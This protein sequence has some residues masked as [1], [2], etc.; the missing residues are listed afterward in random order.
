MDLLMG[1]WKFWNRLKWINLNIDTLRKKMGG[2]SKARNQGLAIAEGEFIYFMDSDDE[3]DPHLI[4]DNVELIKKYDA[5]VVLFGHQT[6]PDGANIANQYTNVKQINCVDKNYFIK[7]YQN[8]FEELVISFFVWN[9]L[10]RKSVIIKNNI[11]FKEN[12]IFGEDALFNLEFFSH[13]K[14][15]VFNPEIYYSYCRRSESISGSSKM[16][17]NRL[18]D[19]I[20]VI[21]A[22]NNLLGDIHPDKTICVKRLINLLFRYKKNNDENIEHMYSDINYILGLPCALGAKYKVKKILLLLGIYT[23][24][25]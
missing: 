13:M 1:H 2:A 24:M 18:M 21:I 7:G 23:N 9:K 22:L 8:Y 11:V 15:I 25:L 12:Q 16:D 17:K 19:E 3:I 20:R 5:D 6:Y 10:Y 4:Q 14:N